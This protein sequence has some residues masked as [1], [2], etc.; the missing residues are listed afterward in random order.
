MYWILRSSVKSLGTNFAQTWCIPKLLLKLLD[1]SQRIFKSL[2]PLAIKFVNVLHG[3]LSL[4]QS[5][6]SFL[7]TGLTSHRCLLKF[8]FE[9]IVRFVGHCFSRGLLAISFTQHAAGFLISL[10]QLGTKF[11]TRSLL[12]YRY[13]I[14]VKQNQNHTIV[15]MV[16][17]H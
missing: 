7:K 9:N 10:I 11:D 8:C 3:C 6:N 17:A 16:T 14:K 12:I 13:H 4:G 1:M 5:K 2:L 15:Q